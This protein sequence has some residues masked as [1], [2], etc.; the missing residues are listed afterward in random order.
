MLQIAPSNFFLD[1]LALACLQFHYF[2]AI[3][4][5]FYNFLWQNRIKIHSKFAPFN[6]I[7]RELAYPSSNVLLC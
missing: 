6:N 3:S 7:L 2:C 1:S 5:Y 4:E